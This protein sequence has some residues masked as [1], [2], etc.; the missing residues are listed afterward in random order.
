MAL[1]LPTRRVISNDSERLVILAGSHGSVNLEVMGQRGWEHI[2]SYTLP[3][4]V[5]SD[6]VVSDHLNMIRVWLTPII[7]RKKTRLLM[8]QLAVLD[9]T[10][11]PK[12]RTR[13][14]SHG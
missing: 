13:Q 11:R 5:P 10:D 9:D 6:S 1:A 3:G 14:R 12:K 4:G 8:S 2:S 7:G